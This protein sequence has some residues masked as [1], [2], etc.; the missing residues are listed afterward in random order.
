MNEQHWGNDYLQ[1]WM[2]QKD[3]AGFEMLAISLISLQASILL[4]SW[5]LVF[6]RILSELIAVKN[7]ITTGV[8]QGH[9]ATLAWT[10][11]FPGNSNRVAATLDEELD[12]E[13]RLSPLYEEKWSFKPEKVKTV[14]SSHLLHLNNLC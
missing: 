6:K 9:L 10:T 11:S 3:K 12:E 1:Q 14:I 2:V 13:L 8:G 4:L 7:I 5:C